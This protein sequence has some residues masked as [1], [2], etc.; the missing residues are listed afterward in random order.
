MDYRSISEQAEHYVRSYFEAHPDDRL[1][2]HNLGHTERVVRAAIEIGQH[3][4]LNDIDFFI[5]RTAAWFHDI[6]YFT[7]GFTGGAPG[8]EQRGAQ[9]AATFLEGTGIATYVSDEV[10]KCIL[11]TQLPQRAVSQAEQIICDADLYHLGT[12]QFGE[13][14]KLMRKETEAVRQTKVGEEEW[15]KSTIALLE[16]HQYYT[17][18]CRLLLNEKYAQNL[19]QLKLKLWEHEHEHGRQVSAGQ[20]GGGAVAKGDVPGEK[21]GG[22]G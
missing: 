17:E 14:N 1:F 18:Y 3:Y 10:Q 22:P 7:G 21:G 4:Q 6:G 8:H 19:A 12:D 15:R 9:L 11:A 16:G 5:V 13:Q 2:Y 20:A